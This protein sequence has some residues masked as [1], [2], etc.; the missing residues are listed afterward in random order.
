VYRYFE[1]FYP[2]LL[3]LGFSLRVVCGTV[4]TIFVQLFIVPVRV[5]H[6]RVVSLD[7]LHGRLSICMPDLSG[8][9][10]GQ[11]QQTASHSL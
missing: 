5:V 4:L 10:L 11:R 7:C 8:L 2:A 1:V 6:S 3:M 9:Y